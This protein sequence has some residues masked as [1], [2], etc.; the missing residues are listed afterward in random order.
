MQIYVNR[1]DS[2]VRGNDGCGIS[3]Q[4]PFSRGQALTGNAPFFII[5]ISGKLSPVFE[6][7]NIRRKTDRGDKAESQFQKWLP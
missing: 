5:P 7:D 2:R 4:S 6:M 1:L 3:S